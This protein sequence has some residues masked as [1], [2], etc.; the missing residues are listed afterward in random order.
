MNAM[1]E[2]ARIVLAQVEPTSNTATALRELI[3]FAEGLTEDLDHYNRN[4]GRAAT[5]IGASGC[6]VDQ[7][8]AVV[9]YVERVA[10]YFRYVQASGELVEPRRDEG[11]MLPSSF[12]GPIEIRRNADGSLDEVVAN[13][14]VVHLEQ[15][16]DNA[17]WM[18]VST[19]DNT[20][21]VHVNFY[22]ET[23][24]EAEADEQHA[25]EP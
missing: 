25:D 1:M 12:V 3:A 21:V 7:L 2:R 22:S 4:V 10:P 13:D 17:W 23:K 5:A 11:G 15:T 9:R 20:H 8:Q 24:I 18:G 6:P 14:I 16:A 19:A